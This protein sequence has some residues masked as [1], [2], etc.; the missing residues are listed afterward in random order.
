MRWPSM[1]RLAGRWLAG[2]GGLIGSILCLT[3]PGTGETTAT[4]DEQI[5][6]TANL[7]TGD[8]ELREF[9][10]LR[11]QRA[12]DKQELAKLVEQLG[13]GAFKERDHADKQLLMR[14]HVALPYL[15]AA[16]DKAPLE[17]VRRAE[18][19]MKTIEAMGP[20]L[21]VAAA[22]L[23]AHRQ[24]PGAVETLLA[25][26][27]SAPDDW[28]EEEVLAC[29]GQL[30]IRAGKVDAKL[31]A[32]LH[33]PFPPVRAAA[34]YVLGRRADVEQRQAV[35]KLLGDPDPQVRERAALALT[36]KRLPQFV[37]DT[38]A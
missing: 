15:K 23:L 37:R 27:P 5:L 16:I 18:K 33:D 11:S 13:A 22:R 25:Y 14:G 1:Q 7:P 34:A 2:L 31:L 26:L 32:A 17:A 21:P 4:L 38:A 30:A 24:A 20:E 35:R 6:R 10:R 28:A 9:L 29:L 12:E 8:A 36:G 3:L 19:L